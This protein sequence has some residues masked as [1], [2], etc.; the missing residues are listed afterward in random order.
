MMIIYTNIYYKATTVGGSI[1]N[2]LTLEREPL[3][4]GETL[5]SR[6]EEAMAKVYEECKSTAKEFNIRG[7]LNAGANIASFLKV[8]DVMLAHGSV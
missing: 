8:A 6:V 2:G 1:F 3:L 4:S 7:D 5:D